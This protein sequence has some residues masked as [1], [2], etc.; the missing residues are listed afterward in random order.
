MISRHTHSKVLFNTDDPEKQL[1]VSEVKTY[2]KKIFGITILKNK[3]EIYQ[4]CQQKN[5]GKPVGF[6]NSK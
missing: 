4:D 5:F 3:I 6:K 2:K 1:V